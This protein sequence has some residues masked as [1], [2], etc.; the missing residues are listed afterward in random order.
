M[1]AV[2]E[3]SRGMNIPSIS[4]VWRR[5]LLNARDPPRVTCTHREYEQVPDTKGT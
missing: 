3:I 5:E 2:G 1:S 4:P